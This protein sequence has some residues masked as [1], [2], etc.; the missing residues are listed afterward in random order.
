MSIAVQRTTSD[1][2][3]ESARRRILIVCTGNSCRSHMAEGFLREAAGD[4]FEVGS[5]G[6]KPAGSVHPQAIKV[7]GEVGIDI[8]AQ[9]S[10][11]LD[12][13]LEAG[14]DTLITVCEEADAACPALAEQVRRY[15]W[16]FD[17]PAAFTGADEAVTARF[18][19]VRDE[20][21]RTFGAYVEG[22]R[23]ALETDRALARA[24]RPL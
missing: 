13:Y 18:R 8:S 23:E 5:A 24:G 21:R 11:G 15:H 17:D 2:S 6:T 7:M 12:G 9:K 19:E 16:R 22:Y 4:L 14:I 3:G 1:S 10:E 20:I